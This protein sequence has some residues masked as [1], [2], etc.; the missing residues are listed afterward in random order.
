MSYYRESFIYPPLRVF[1]DL[2][3]VY[4][5]INF[6]NMAF[7]MEQPIKIPNNV[8][9]YV[10]LREMTFLNSKYNINDTNNTLVTI[11]LGNF[12]TK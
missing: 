12:H 10:S 8:I 3:G 2:A 6:G 9:G 7:V 4:S 5:Y 1:L 11:S